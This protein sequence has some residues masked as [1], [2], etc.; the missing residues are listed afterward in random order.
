LVAAETRS[1][2]AILTYNQI[3]FGIMCSKPFRFASHRFLVAVVLILPM[4]M[5][6]MV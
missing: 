6:Q 2:F 4:L 5:N 3:H 1:L